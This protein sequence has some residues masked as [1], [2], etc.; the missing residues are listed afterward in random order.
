[1]SDA[2]ENNDILVGANSG[3]I[4]NILIIVGKIP[5]LIGFKNS[6]KLGLNLSEHYYFGTALYCL[7]GVSFFPLCLVACG[8]W[9]C[10]ICMQP[11]FR[12]EFCANKFLF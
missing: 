6:F 11:E 7:L 8:D 3:K 2:Y 4:E 10:F 5:L 12:E 1:M 9:V